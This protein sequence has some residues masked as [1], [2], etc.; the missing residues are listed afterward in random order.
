MPAVT[1]L[2]PAE[3]AIGARRRLKRRLV[4][5]GIDA[6]LLVFGCLMLLPLI[7]LVANAFKTPQPPSRTDVAA[8]PPTFP[9]RRGTRRRGAR[10][11]TNLRNGQGAAADRARRDRAATNRSGR[12]LLHHA[13]LLAARV[14]ASAGW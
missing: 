11:R 12:D 2:T 9:G 8:G 7:L 1:D 3:R 10:G 14:P 6:F 13:A 4:N 5:A